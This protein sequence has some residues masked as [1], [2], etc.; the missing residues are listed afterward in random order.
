[1]KNLIIAVITL[2]SLTFSNNT[3]AQSE[4]SNQWTWKAGFTLSPQLVYKFDKEPPKQ[5]GAPLL[6]ITSISNDDWFFATFYNFSQNQQ[7]ILISKSVS[8]K[9]STYYFG[10]VKL[11]EKIN[12]SGIGVT[13]PPG[14]ALGFLEFGKNFGGDVADDGKKPFMVAGVLVPFHAVIKKW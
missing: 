1:M 11:D 12:Y 4:Q 14:K 10:T 13:T 3:F 2:L 8:P 7:G 5:V 6:G 9:L